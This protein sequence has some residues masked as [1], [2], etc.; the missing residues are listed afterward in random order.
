MRPG[1]I[2]GF[3]GGLIAF[4]TIAQEPRGWKQPL[5]QPTIPP[6]VAG[7]GQTPE[8]K[9]PLVHPTLPPTLAAKALVKQHLQLFVPQQGTNG[10]RMTLTNFVI[11]V[12]GVT[13]RSNLP[14][15]NLFMVPFEQ[16]LIGGA[17]LPSEQEYLLQWQPELM[18]PTYPPKL[19]PV[20]S[21]GLLNPR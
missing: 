10:L 4:A 6:K 11:I 3:F 13:N 18:Y 19:A 7:S 15:T 9:M 5:L 20:Q 8:W 17:V 1:L 21:L 12:P 2:V 14:R 16:G